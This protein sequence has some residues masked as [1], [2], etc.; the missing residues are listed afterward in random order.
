MEKKYAGFDKREVQ[1]WEKEVSRRQYDR[2][3]NRIPISQSKQ[4]NSQKKRAKR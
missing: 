1:Q 3:Y 4:I 2:M